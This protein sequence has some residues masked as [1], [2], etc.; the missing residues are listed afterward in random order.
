MFG[1]IYYFL[2]GSQG[3]RGLNIISLLSVSSVC[4]TQRRE[5]PLREK[6][7]FDTYKSA[8]SYHAELE[9]TNGR[10]QREAVW[11]CVYSNNFLY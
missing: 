8:S 1:W 3:R 11:L 9:F 10:S 5:P 6:D 4:T 2:H 7:R